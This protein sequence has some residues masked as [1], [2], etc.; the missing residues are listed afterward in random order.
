MVYGK[1]SGPDSMS[2]TVKIFV[3][4]RLKSER[5]LYEIKNIFPF[6]TDSVQILIWTRSV[7]NLF[8]RKIYLLV[9]YVVQR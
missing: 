8:W 1:M 6:S 2:E 9:K 5:I 3:W 7:Q 4:S